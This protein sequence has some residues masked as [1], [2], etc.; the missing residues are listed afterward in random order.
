MSARDKRPNAPKEI[1]N[2]FFVA[3]DSRLESD[4]VVV[5][6]HMSKDLEYCVTDIEGNAICLVFFPAVPTEQSPRAAYPSEEVD[7]P[8]GREIPREVNR[9]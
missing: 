8:S 2:R 6:S 5:G 7:L 9:D 3:E 1:R 4:Y